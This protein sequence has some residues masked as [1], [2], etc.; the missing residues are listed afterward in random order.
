MSLFA[1][2][3]SRRRGLTVPMAMWNVARDP[4]HYAQLVLLLIGT[5]ALGTASLAL[6][7]TRDV[8]AWTVAQAET[9]A[10][11]RLTFDP[12]VGVDP[13][14]ALTLPDVAAGEALLVTRT[15][16][17]AGRPDTI[18]FGVEP[19]TF[20]ATFPTLTQA[21]QPLGISPDAAL[22]ASTACRVHA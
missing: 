18:L 3:S 17:R 19:D 2:L 5:L 7:A 13:A 11:A 22:A 8:G 14:A 15:P 9:G 6:A 4:G 1:W 21:V 12:G 10:Y 20:A 16:T